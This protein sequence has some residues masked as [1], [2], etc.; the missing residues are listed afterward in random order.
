MTSAYDEI[1]SD[2]GLIADA[3]YIG[4]NYSYVK[5]R[6]NENA[7]WHD[8]EP[9]TPEDVVWSFEKLTEL[10]PQQRFYY[11]HVTGAEVTGEHEVTFTFDVEGNRELPHIVGQLLVLPKHWW[12]GTD[13]NGQSARHRQRHAGTAPWLGRLQGARFQPGEIYRI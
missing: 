12:T 1:S 8:G 9:I 7:R 11:N 10:N 2:Y 13:A 3:L 6:L 5:Y 4:K